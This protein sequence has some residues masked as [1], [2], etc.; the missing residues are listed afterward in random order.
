MST[1]LINEATFIL[2]RLFPLVVPQLSKTH[3]NE[4]A[5]GLFDGTGSYFLTFNHYNSQRETIG[6]KPH[7]DSSQITLLYIDREGLEAHINGQ[8]WSIMPKKGY[9]VVFLG[10]ALEL[11]VHDQTKLQ[12]IKHRVSQVKHRDRISFA[13]FSE[14]RHLSPVNYVTPTGDVKQ[15]YASYDEFADEIQKIA[16][17]IQDELSQSES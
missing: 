17:G 3:W 6:L 4:A 16:L 5:P 8:W 12:A 2:E 1:L 11:L 9:L 14:N 13:L 15:A 7:K 10:Q